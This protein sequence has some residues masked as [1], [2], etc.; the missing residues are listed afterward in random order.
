M[1]SSLRIIYCCA[2]IGATLIACTTLLNWQG[3]I[4]NSADQLSSAADALVQPRAKLDRTEH[5]FG[6]V[7]AGALLMA[8]FQVTNTGSKRL[9]VR[10]Q[11]RGCECVTVGR[12][13][14]V[15]PPGGSQNLTPGLDTK[16]ISGPL[17]TTI[18]YRTNDPSR[19]TFTLVLRADIQ[20]PASAPATE[21]PLEP[22]AVDGI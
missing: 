14:V 3:S 4:L 20:P 12:P 19:P 7:P 9:V 15:V 17:R 6:R 1:S 11:S 2:A 10:E 16:K 13:E 5:D 18:V 8:G 21:P 22:I